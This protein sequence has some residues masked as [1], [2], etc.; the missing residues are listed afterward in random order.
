MLPQEARE[1]N[2]LLQLSR[3]P[4]TRGLATTMDKFRLFIDGEFVDATRGSVSKPRS[5]DRP[6]AL[7]PA[8]SPAT[9]TAPSL[10]ALAFAEGPG[11]V[12]PR[13]AASCFTA[14]PT[15]SPR[16]RAMAELET[17]DTGKVMRE[18]R[19]VIAYVAEYYRYFAGMADKIE[20]VLPIDKPDLEVYTRREPLGVV[21]A[22]VPWNNQLFLSAPRSDRLLPP[23]TPST[24]RPP[25]TARRR[26]SISPG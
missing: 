12:P 5:R 24:S 23:A 17:R 14:S 9:P 6:W 21:A 16:R 26:C 7:M 13:P 4:V 18:T 25:R 2:E 20:S 19:A 1:L 8:A 10:A 3:S 15:W 22:I 11:P